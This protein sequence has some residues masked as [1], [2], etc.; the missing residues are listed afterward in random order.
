MALNVED[1]IAGIATAPGEAGIGIIRVSGNQA[2]SIVDQIF[3]SKKERKVQDQ[4]AYTIAYGWIYE[5]KQ[6]LDEVLVSVM[7]APH[8]FTAENVVEINTHGGSLITQTILDLL[9]KRGARL[10]NP[11]EF[12]QRAFINGRIDLTQA[13]AIHDLIQAKTLKGINQAVNQLKGKL[14]EKIQDLKKSASWVLALI[15][16]SIDFPEEDVIFTNQKEVKERLQ[17]V[18]E[19]LQRLIQTATT[20]RIIREGYRV[21][22]V[23]EPNVGKS[24][25]MNCLLK[26][27]RSI[28]THLPGTTRDIIEEY[29]NINGIPVSITDTAGIRETKDLIEQ[30]GIER[31]HSALEKADLILWIIDSSDPAFKKPYQEINPHCSTL[32]VFNKNDLKHISTE[33][34]P[35][36]V[37]SFSSISINA[38]SDEE[39]DLLRKEIF[40]FATQNTDSISESTTLTNL[41]QKNAAE[42]ALETVKEAENALEQGFGE[43]Y[44]AVDL[45]RVLDHLGNI[46]GETTPDD[47]LNQIFSNFCIGK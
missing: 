16:A 11:G 33:E 10:A 28:V 1:T 19:E 21:I 31:A 18:R 35:E 47:M 29:V 41:R 42:N 12:T 5:N 44:L 8:S 38:Q 4:K 30:I 43:E 32:M 40:H 26:E 3:Q 36:E 27:K 14:F 34:I 37:R 15:N 46:V 22:L 17:F 2:F 20:G 45:T 7:R 9:L 13:E 23:G 24:S 6:L 39:V 25:I